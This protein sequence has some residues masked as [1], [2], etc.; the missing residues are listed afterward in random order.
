MSEAEAPR[1]V[2]AV[3]PTAM[4]SGAERVLVDYLTHLQASDWTVRCACPEGPL[5][6]QLAARG[7]PWAP[8][9]DLKLPAGNKVRAVTDMARAWRAAGRSFGDLAINADL[10]LVN[11]LMALPALRMAGLSAPLVWLVHDVIVRPDLQL[12]VRGAAGA[13]DLAVPVSEAAAVFPRRCD[14]PATVVRNGTDFPVPLAT[15]ATSPALPVVGVSAVLTPWKGHEV[16][17]QAAALVDEPAR[18]E[19]MGGA[20]PKDEAHRRRLVALADVPELR[21]RV[22][23][24]GHVTAPLDQLRSWTIAVSPSIDPEACPLNVL[25]AMSVGV[26]MVVT[27]HGGAAELI[28]DAGLK[29]PPRDPVALADGITRLLRDDATRATASRRGP[30]IVAEHYQRHDVARRFADVLT[31]AV[32]AGPRVR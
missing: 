10:V 28:D 23:F 25:E 5:T 11:G 31:A 13:V 7:L 2:L 20:P 19:L 3:N 4:F 18:F 9:E 6:D 30:E 1:R 8:I 27:N 16:F 15:P 26:P 14:I 12:L 21:D 24:L 17:L 32:T 29:V 22:A